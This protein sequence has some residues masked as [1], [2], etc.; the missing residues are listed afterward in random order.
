VERRSVLEW[1]ICN[2]AWERAYHREVVTCL[3]LLASFGEQTA[4][5]SIL[6]V[7]DHVIGVDDHVWHEP[8]TKHTR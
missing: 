5:S 4:H 7:V 2:Q 1:G 6:E 3:L 8:I